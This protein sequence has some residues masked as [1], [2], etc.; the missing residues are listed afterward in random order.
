MR[1]FFSPISKSSL[2]IYSSGRPAIRHCAVVHT[3]IGQKVCGVEFPIILALRHDIQM[4][5]AHF[6]CLTSTKLHFTEKTNQMTSLDDDEDSVT[7]EA[8]AQTEVRQQILNFY[9]I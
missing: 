2:V 8:N 9:V 5:N 3:S 6:F 4:W 1:I 7:N